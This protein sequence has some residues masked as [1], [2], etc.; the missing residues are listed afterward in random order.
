MGTTVILATHDREIINTLG[1]RVVTLDKGKLI[2][3][4]EK[5]RYMA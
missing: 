3:D 1:K 4:E 5:G 2:K